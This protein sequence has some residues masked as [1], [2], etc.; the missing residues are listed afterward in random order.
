MENPHNHKA[1]SMIS[2]VDRVLSHIGRIT[3]PLTTLL[4]KYAFSWTPEATKAFEHLK[5]EMCQ[6]PVLAMPASQ[7]PLLWNVMPREMELVL[8]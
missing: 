5:E 3:K 1:S 8:F 7:K 4:K 6:S 2:H